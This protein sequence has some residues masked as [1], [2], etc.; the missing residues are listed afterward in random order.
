MHTMHFGQI[1]SIISVPLLLK[2]FLSK[3]AF[4]GFSVLFMYNP[5]SMMRTAFMSMSRGL[6]TVFW[7]TNLGKIHPLFLA[8]PQLLIAFQ[9]GAGLHEMLSHHYEVLI[10]HCCSGCL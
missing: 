2:S 7:T 9:K 3:W 1:F 8:I 5:V 10:N 4:S 6:F